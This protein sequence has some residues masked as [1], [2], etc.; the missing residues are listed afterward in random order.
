MQLD[1]PF[2]DFK[3]AQQIQIVGWTKGTKGTKGTNIG[4]NSLRRRRRQLE[5][6]YAMSPAIDMRLE[7]SSRLIIR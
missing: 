2:T 1:P 6:G 7:E 4:L 3:P 5:P